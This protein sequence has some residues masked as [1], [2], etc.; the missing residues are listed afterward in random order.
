[1]QDAHESYIETIADESEVE[2]ADE[3]IIDL[4]TRYE[5]LE[6]LQARNTEKAISLE[7]QKDK[8]M[9]EKLQESIITTEKLLQAGNVEEVVFKGL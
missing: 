1:M 7:S 2:Q 3:W 5:S 6:D 4:Q 9:K 8:E